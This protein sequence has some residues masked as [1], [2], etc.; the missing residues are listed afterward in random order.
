VALRTARIDPARKHKKEANRMQ[1]EITH[2]AEV[3]RA[4]TEMF[5]KITD[6]VAHFL[7][8]GDRGLEYL[9]AKRLHTRLVAICARS[10][11]DITEQ[12]SCLDRYLAISG[13]QPEA[14][15]AVMHELEH[16]LRDVKEL[17]AELK[18]ERSDFVLDSTYERLIGVLHGE[19]RVLETPAR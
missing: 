12:Q 6:D 8:T 11:W 13:P 7:Q 18:R 17:L 10:T 3:I 14:W 19:A 15:K 5:G 16:M 4:L 2:V 1:I 9:A